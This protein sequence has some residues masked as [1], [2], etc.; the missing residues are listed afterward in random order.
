[1]QDNGFPLENTIIENSYI[2]DILSE[3][4]QSNLKDGSNSLTLTNPDQS[5]QILNM[6][7]LD[8]ICQKYSFTPN[9]I[10]IDTDG[11]DFKVI[12][13]ALQ[14]IQKYQPLILFEWDD[15]FLRKLNEDSLSIFSFLLDKG[16]DKLIIFDNFGN[17]LTSLDT[18]DI[19]NLE[20][21]IKY[22]INS[23][24][25]IYYYD[26]LAIPTKYSS[27]DLLQCLK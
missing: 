2:N 14:T 9:F 23:N 12:R 18:K 19:N 21:L 26:V 16:Y 4:L 24:Q 6:N 10:K 17:L 3:A 13:S 11:F 27:Q 7:T 1:M 22:T 5:K 8:N 25:N 15:F 20:I